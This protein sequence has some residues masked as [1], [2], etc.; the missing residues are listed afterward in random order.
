MNT[1]DSFYYDFLILC[2]RMNELIVRTHNAL[3][4]GLYEYALEY[5]ALNE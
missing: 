4:S 5:Q 2:T 3:T 1:Y